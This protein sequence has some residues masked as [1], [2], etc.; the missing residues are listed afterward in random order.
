MDFL[1]QCA[2]SFL[3]ELIGFFS[4]LYQRKLRRRLV[5]YVDDELTI[6]GVADDGAPR[7]KRAA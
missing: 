5:G 7:M 4:E 3:D 1:E 6:I 2:G